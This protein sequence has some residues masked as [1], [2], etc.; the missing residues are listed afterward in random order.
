MYTVTIEEFESTA[1][2][3]V[4]DELYIRTRNYIYQQHEGKWLPAQNRFSLGDHQELRYLFNSFW[5]KYEEN[6]INMYSYLP[7]QSKPYKDVNTLQG[8][9]LEG[10]LLDE[11]RLDY[12]ALEVIN[13]KDFLVIGNLKEPEPSKRILFSLMDTITQY[14]NHVIVRGIFE[15]AS[16]TCFDKN[17]T[18]VWETPLEYSRNGRRGLTGEPQLFDNIIYLNMPERISHQKIPTPMEIGAF[19]A[20]TGEALWKDTLPCCV[21]NAD[22]HGNEVFIASEYFLQIRDVTTGNVVWELE[23]FWE[24]DEIPHH[25]YPLSG[26]DLLINFQFKGK[27]LIIDRVSKII[28]QTIIFPEKSG[29]CFTTLSLPIKLSNT[30]WFWDTE[31]LH[32]TQNSRNSAVVTIDLDNTNNITQ[33]SDSPA[34][35]S[36][37][38]TLSEGDT[39]STILHTDV[40]LKP[41]PKHKLKGKTVESGEKEYFLEMTHHDLDEIVRYCIII[42]SNFAHEKGRA[43]QSSKPDRKHNGNI[44]VTI[45]K[46]AIVTD[47]ADSE[48]KK[49][50]QN[51]KV[52][53]EHT[54]ERLDIKSGN[55]SEFLIDVQLV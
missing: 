45:N 50:L 11:N 25:L 41:R 35:I 15:N 48:V 1:W 53:S 29:Y 5:S 31:F 23:P 12:I 20:D 42:L 46:A 16:L 28:K 22:L 47:K 44:H 34:E 30:Q 37:K 36:Q 49:H 39:E 55:N 26:N 2:P 21:R 13:R 3:C 51:I 24:A 17:L 52:V 19:S 43:G 14:N 33:G 54:F 27:A 4:S 7:I 6:N 9:F 10:V 38:N 40:I 32:F 8:L 18:K